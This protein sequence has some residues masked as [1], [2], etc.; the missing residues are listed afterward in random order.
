LLKKSIK[1]KSFDELLRLSFNINWYDE[2]VGLLSNLNVPWI[3][4]EN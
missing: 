4:N 2:A 1:P 3:L